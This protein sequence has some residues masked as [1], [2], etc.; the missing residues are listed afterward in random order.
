MNLSSNNSTATLNNNANNIIPT[1]TIISDFNLIFDDILNWIE[2]EYGR[3]FIANA[4]Q[5]FVNLIGSNLYEQEDL[6]ANLTRYFFDLLIFN[7]N[8]LS[9]NL[10]SSPPGLFSKYLFSKN[11]KAL[12]DVN[13]EN[14]WVSQLAGSRHSLFQ[15]QKNSPTSL[16]LLDMIAKT[17]YEITASADQLFYG[18]EKGNILQAFIFP[19][20]NINLL[21]PGFIIH[22]HLAKGFL[23]DYIAKFRN[24]PSQFQQHEFFI[25]LIKL[26]LR[27]KRLGHLKT[28]D[29]YH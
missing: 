28:Q 17:Q 3:E 1:H 12:C 25:F 23:Q 20:C 4:R 7:N 15:I 13:S 26:F 11:Y 19:V 16:L 10:F 21:S 6:G 18:L 27:S 9:L 22:P 14:T 2:Q 8:P 5:R 29:I 24:Q